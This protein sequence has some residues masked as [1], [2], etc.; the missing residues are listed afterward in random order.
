MHSPEAWFTAGR[1]KYDTT[2]FIFF[3]FSNRSFSIVTYS[4]FTWHQGNICPLLHRTTLEVFNPRLVVPIMNSSQLMCGLMGFISPPASKAYLV[5]WTKEEADKSLLR[6]LSAETGIRRQRGE[7]VRATHFYLSLIALMDAAV[8][9]ILSTHYPG[10]VHLCIQVLPGDT[11]R[12]ECVMPTGHHI[13]CTENAVTSRCACV[14]ARVCACV[15]VYVCARAF[16]NCSV[17]LHVL[18]TVTVLFKCRIVLP[19]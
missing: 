14:Y 18:C 15:C 5:D 8:A 4:F 7:D 11:I 10:Y 13:L 19:Y 17:D 2:P 3:S 1:S 9:W 16:V 12:L 6:V